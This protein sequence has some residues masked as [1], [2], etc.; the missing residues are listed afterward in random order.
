MHHQQSAGLGGYWGSTFTGVCCATNASSSGI[1]Q[2]AGAG[3]HYLATDSIY[4][5]AGITNIGPALLANLAAKTTYPP[6]IYSNTAVGGGTFFT[7]R[8]A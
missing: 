2:V 5:N 3:S 8:P 7:L 1:F 4:R 6:L